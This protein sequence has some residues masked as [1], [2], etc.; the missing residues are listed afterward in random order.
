MRKIFIWILI[1]L[2]MMT[3][4]TNNNV[5][6]ATA[7]I[8][9]VTTDT[10]SDITT[11][12]SETDN[13]IITEL[14]SEVTEAENTETEPSYKIQQPEEEL[15]CSID[16]NYDGIT[17]DFFISKNIP[18]DEFHIVMYDD[19][20]KTHI[21][22]D[23]AINRTDKIDIY[24]V[25]LTSD[26]EYI[27]EYRYYAV[28]RNSGYHRSEVNLLYTGGIQ[29]KGFSGY[30]YGEDFYNS[31]YCYK[32]N[33]IISKEGFDDLLTDTPDF[34]KKYEDMEYV[35]TIDLNDFLSEEYS[36]EY[37]ANISICDEMSDIS[38]Y[39]VQNDIFGRDLKLTNERYTYYS[40]ETDSI[41]VYKRLREVQDYDESLQP[42]IIEGPEVYDY[43]LCLK[44]SDG[45][46]AELLYLGTPGE[47]W[48]VSYYAYAYISDAPT[49]SGRDRDIENFNLIMNDSV[50]FLKEDGWE[51]ERTIKI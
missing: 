32:F 49:Q 17:E 6:E 47:D 35:E 4:C 9:S 39:N 14:Q 42:F 18:Y 36:E 5:Q 51:Y 46:T 44:A 34:L 37:I 29:D 30:G 31:I 27:P 22:S 48:I 7:P 50:S 23:T 12:A 8:T 28:F 2:F 10:I 25:Q 26:G 3:S 24:K 15:F 21:V 20:D 33:S 13:N 1:S 45:K 40:V 16:L 11:A 19:T 41:E 38:L 43:L